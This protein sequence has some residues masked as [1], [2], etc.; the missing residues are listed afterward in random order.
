MPYITPDTTPDATICRVLLIPNDLRWLAAVQGALDELTKSYNWEQVGGISAQDAAD[1]S[2]EL[3]NQTYESVC[4]PIGAVIPYV[5]GFPPDGY[6]VCDGARYAKADYP[7]LGA[8]IAFNLW[9]PSD[10]DYFFVPDL[11]DKFVMGGITGN[12]VNKQGGQ[13]EVTLTEDQLPQV[14]V[15]QDAHGH[16]AIAHTHNQAGHAHSYS[17]PSIN[18]DVEGP[19]VPDPFGAGLPMLPALTD[20]KAPEI[21]PAGGD[22]NP[23]TATNQPFGGGEAHPN[24]PPYVQMRY[25]IKAK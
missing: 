9:D 12:D 17:T 14:T 25:I 4:M 22:V 13:E 10:N 8:I 1:R 11:N 15:I 19:G 5:G 24:L 7:K 3:V 2:L 23:A 21:F 6:L 16:Q 20:W 18:L